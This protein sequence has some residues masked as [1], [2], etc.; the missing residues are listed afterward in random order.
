MEAPGETVSF[1]EPSSK[2][3]CSLTSP[4]GVSCLVGMITNV[5]ALVGGDAAAYVAEEVK[6]AS[7]M[8]PRA[9]ISTTI[10]NGFLGF[11]MLVY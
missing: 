4:V 1:T 3:R 9:M 7:K 11:V 8:L 2:L 5:G 6:S 10:V